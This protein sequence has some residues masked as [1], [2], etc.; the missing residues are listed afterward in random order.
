M[1]DQ[2]NASE[3]PCIDPKGR[4]NIPLFN[5]A[6]DGL[7]PALNAKETLLYDILSCRES[8]PC[9]SQ[10]SGVCLH[11]SVWVVRN[12]LMARGIVMEPCPE[13]DYDTTVT[14][15]VCQHVLVMN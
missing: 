12:D 11:V 15:M 2:S 5:W 7:E 14:A 8:G 3:R 13:L 4:C 6:D 10:L 1:Q 9:D